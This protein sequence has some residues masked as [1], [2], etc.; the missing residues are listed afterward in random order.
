MNVITGIL[1]VVLLLTAGW[2]STGLGAVVAL[3]LQRA[4]KPILRWPSQSEAMYRIEF[5]TSLSPADWQILADNL[6]GNG[7]DSPNLPT[8]VR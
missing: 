1:T 8:R 7:S 6:P 3:N 2:P 4:L 5:A